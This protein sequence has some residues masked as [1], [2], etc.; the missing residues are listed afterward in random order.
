MRTMPETP[1]PKARVLA[2]VVRPMTS[3]S[4]LK[5]GPPELP[6]LMFTS[7]MMARSRPC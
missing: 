4:E 5:S 7:E 1:G 6:G 2:E 3:P